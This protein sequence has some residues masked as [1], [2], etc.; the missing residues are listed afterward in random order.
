MHQATHSSGHT[1]STDV[2]SYANSLI[3][4]EHLFMNL[5]VLIT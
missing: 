1:G 5:E 2:P 3:N 4:W